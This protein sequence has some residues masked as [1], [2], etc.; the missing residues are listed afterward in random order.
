MT[1]H[2]EMVSKL[3]KP[4]EAILSQLTPD[5]CHLNHMAIGLIGEAAEIIEGIEKGD[6]DNIIEEGGDGCFYLTALF[7][8]RGMSFDD[9]R[10]KTPD[11]SVPVYDPDKKYLIVC[12][13]ILDLIKKKTIYR[14][15]I[16]IED[17]DNL[18]IQARDYL[19]Y[20]LGEFSISI[21]ACLD[22]NYKKLSVRYQDHQ[23][24]DEQAQARKDK[25][26]EGN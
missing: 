18:L 2:E 16:I 17:L 11:R 25:Q 6:V 21:G 5:D 3:V 26:N 10:N 20:A 9:E 22:H 12:G 14:K 8:I 13:K 15:D 23:Y 19:R 4:G 1:K 24:S 7:Q